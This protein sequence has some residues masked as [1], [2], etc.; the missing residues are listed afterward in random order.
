MGLGGRTLS[1]DVPLLLGLSQ[2]SAVRVPHRENAVTTTSR[3]I[4]A[5]AAGLTVLLAT[6][7]AG[8]ATAPVPAVK[9]T[10]KVEASEQ[11][12]ATSASTARVEAV[13]HEEAKADTDAK[14]HTVIRWLP[15][16]PAANGCPALPAHVEQETTTETH[17]ATTHTADK[18]RASNVAAKQ[19]QQASAQQSV[20]EL[21]TSTPVRP[22]WSVS[23]MPGAQV[24]GSK[25]VTLF[26]PLVVGAS[27][28]HRFIG[29]ISLGVWGSTSGAI[30]AT[31][32]TEF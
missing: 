27:V 7:L 18:R 1:R 22:A 30:G 17:A 26:G 29:P 20:V 2:L 31:L 23:L 24:L 9:D 5:S 14:T 16:V 13:A 28:E 3:W 11:S 8:R 32:R 10:R 19:E 4:L 6:F 21:H 15:A 12:H 25:A